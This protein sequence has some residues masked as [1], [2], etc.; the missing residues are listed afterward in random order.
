MFFDILIEELHLNTVIADGKGIEVNTSSFRY[1][2]KDLMPSEEILRLYL[3]L[4]GN[5]ITIG[6]D[7]HK[8]EQL[9]A[10]IDETKQRLKEIGFQSFCTYEKMKP[11]FHEL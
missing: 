6:S 3:E 11:V 9:G 7:S 5:I 10:Y 1:G 8:P 2:I 4:G